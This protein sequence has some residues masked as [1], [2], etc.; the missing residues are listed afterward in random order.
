MLFSCF[1]VGLLDWKG[2]ENC[3]GDYRGFILQHS[4]PPEAGEHGRMEF[5]IVQFEALGGVGCGYAGFAGPSLYL[6]HR[7]KFNVL[8]Q[9]NSP[10]VLTCA[11]TVLPHAHTSGI[12]THTNV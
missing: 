8:I 9:R 11:H 5:E 4:E 7:A 1:C 6:P 3:L 2:S 10:T 12:D